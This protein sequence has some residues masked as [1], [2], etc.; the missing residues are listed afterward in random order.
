[1]PDHISLMA[2]GDLRDAINAAQ[3]GDRAAAACALASIDPASWAA[4]EQR[5]ATLG[6]TLTALTT[7]KED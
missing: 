6:G 2:A 5:L 7:P 3:R 1:M 4:I